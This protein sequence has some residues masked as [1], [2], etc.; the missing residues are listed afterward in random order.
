MGIAIIVPEI[1]ARLVYTLKWVFTEQLG[2]TCEV[3]TEKPADNDDYFVIHYSGD[4]TEGF[5]IPDAGLLFEK[6]I[7]H[8]D[9]GAGQWGDLPV[10][11]AVNGNEATIPFD[12]FSAV[13]HCI[14]RYEEYLPFTP[15]KHQ[16]YPSTESILFKNN[17]LDRPIVDEWVFKFGTLLA[18][19]GVNIK[20]KQFEFQPTYDIDIAWSYKHKGLKRT[21][22]GYI[23]DAAESNFVAIQE[24]TAVLRGNNEDPYFSFDFTDKLHKENNLS[25]IYFILAADKS[26]PFDKHILPSQPDMKMLIKELSEKYQVGMHPSYETNEDPKLFPQEQKILSAIIGKGVTISRQ[27]YIKL[28]LPQ[29]Y[30][31]LVELGIQQDYSMGYG[32]HLGFRAGTSRPFYWYDLLE[33]QQTS[34]QVFPFSFMDTTAHYELELSTEVAFQKLNNIKEKLQK[35]GGLLI[36]VFHNFSLG[37]DK[38]WAGWAAAYADFIKK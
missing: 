15:D 6:G 17:L 8:Q 12:L 29:T 34:L 35:V 33:E 38:E 20:A 32:T 9:I 1:T 7:K 23:K 4:C 3:L 31:K 13:F 30:R 21:L 24:R 37:T 36:T 27:H 11:F 14:S 25:P 22:G 19:Y 5:K 16:R 28:A 10:L 26:G 18:S 2:V